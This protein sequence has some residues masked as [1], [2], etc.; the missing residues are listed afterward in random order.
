MAVGYF[1]CYSKLIT[2][3]FFIR[4]TIK[5][6]SIS[7]NGVTFTN[8]LAVREI[9]AQVFVFDSTN[10]NKTNKNNNKT[11]RPAVMHGT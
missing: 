7:G 4:L 3:F 11:V 2:I 10:N 5:E 8:A 1:K 9:E 6:Q